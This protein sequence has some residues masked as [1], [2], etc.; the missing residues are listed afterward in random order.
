[1]LPTASAASGTATNAPRSRRPAA[2]PTKVPRPNS[3]RPIAKA[4]TQVACI[5]SL[6][7]PWMRYDAT[8]YASPTSAPQA[9]RRQGANRSPIAS[10]VSA[11]HAAIASISPPN[12]CTR[13]TP[14]A[15][16]P[17]TTRAWGPSG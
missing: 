3:W 12:P 11:A 10:G 14:M 8:R 9:I 13:L 16:E 15:L 2:R 1:M 4:S 7:A 6:K 5:V 17:A